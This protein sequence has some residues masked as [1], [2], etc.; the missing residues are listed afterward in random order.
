MFAVAIVGA[1]GL[2]GRTCLEVL[3]ERRFPIGRLGLYA[4]HRSAG[5]RLRFAGISARP[6][7]GRW[8]SRCAPAAA[9]K[10]RFRVTSRW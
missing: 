10:S 2:V 3:A 7:A 6:R 9:R 8:S 4:S 1:T 5:R